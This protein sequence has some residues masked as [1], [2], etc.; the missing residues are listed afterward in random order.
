M[1]TLFSSIQR[2]DCYC[3]PLIY[4]VLHIHVKSVCKR[5][6]GKWAVLTRSTHWVCILFQHSK[7]VVIMAAWGHFPIPYPSLLADLSLEEKKIT[8]GCQFH[9][10]IIAQLQ[11][12][13]VVVGVLVKSECPEPWDLPIARISYWKAWV[14]WRFRCLLSSNCS[15]LQIGVQKHFILKAKTIKSDR[16]VIY[17]MTHRIWAHE[18]PIQKT[19]TCTYK[20]GISACFPV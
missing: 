20:K 11:M 19:S 15:S 8:S 14:W 16:Y 9:W 3:R 5:E 13:R 10:P 12:F 1:W 7:K 2:E 4:K 18:N 6:G 17:S